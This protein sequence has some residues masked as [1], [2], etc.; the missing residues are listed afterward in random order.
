MHSVTVGA[1]RAPG[2]ERTGSVDQQNPSEAGADGFISLPV[3]RP[4]APP[5]AADPPAA[6]PAA[7]PPAAA[8]RGAPDPGAAAPPAAQPDRGQVRIGAEDN[9]GDSLMLN[10]LL[11]HVLEERCSDLHLTTGAPPTV[12]RNG[13]LAALPDRPVMTPQLVQK[14]IYAILTQKQR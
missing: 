2:Q 13:H 8:E 4:P 9:S 5:L 3:I 10:D 7:A 12:R 1:G 11:I 6:P 14:M